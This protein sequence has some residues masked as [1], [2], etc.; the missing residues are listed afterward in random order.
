MKALPRSATGAATRPVSSGVVPW[1]S[2]RPG[3]TV[4]VAALLYA[5]RVRIPLGCGHHGGPDYDAVLPA[6][7]AAGRGIRAPRRPGGRGGCRSRFAGGLGDRERRQSVR[8]RMGDANRSPGPAGRT[9]R[10]RRGP[11]APVGSGSISSGGGRPAAARRRGDQRQHRATGS[12]GE[13]GARAGRSEQA[14]DIITETIEIAHELVSELLRDDQET[15]GVHART[16]Q[17]LAR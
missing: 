12:R 1:F 8:G 13:V 9:A 11:V 17:L 7:R 14:L 6:D 5:R 3:L 4:A 16:A 15:S 2:R 10:R